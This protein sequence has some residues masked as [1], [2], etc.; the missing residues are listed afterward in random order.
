MIILA[1]M[2]NFFFDVDGTLLPGGRTIPESTVKALYEAKRQGCRLFLCTGRS[3]DEVI[4]ELYALPFDGGV[5]S[6]GAHIKV[7][8]KVIYHARTT[9]AQRKVFFDA[10][11][12]YSLMWVIQTEDGSYLTQECLDLYTKLLWE[13]SGKRIEF[14][15]F[16]IVKE[17]PQEKPIVKMFIL[18]DTCKALEARRDMEPILSTVNNV[19]GIPETMAAEITIP[20]I[21]KSSGILKVLEYLGDGIETSVGVGD[22]ENDVDMID[23]CAIGISMGNGC[24]ELKRHADFITTDADADGIYHAIMKVLGGEWKK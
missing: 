24:E 8:D 10:V 21:S 20:N 22:G 19:V 16:N 5:F 6:S 17:F 9:E 7:G 2:K 18:S 1:V 4:P 23:T 11:D 13:I 12:K 15:G 3:Q 14:S